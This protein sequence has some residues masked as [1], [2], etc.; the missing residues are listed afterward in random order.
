MK[1]TRPVK[2]QATARLLRLLLTAGIAVVLAIVLFRMIMSDRQRGAPT[3][4]TK[5]DGT[6]A[7]GNT[8]E[9]RLTGPEDRSE[10]T[11]GKPETYRGEGA[12]PSD[13][14]KLVWEMTIEMSDRTLQLLDGSVVVRDFTGEPPISDL[15][16]S[17]DPHTYRIDLTESET[18]SVRLDGTYDPATASL[19]STNETGQFFIYLTP[20]K[21]G[22]PLKAVPARFLPERE[23]TPLITIQGFIRTD[24][25]IVGTFRSVFGPD[26]EYV[27]EP[28]SDG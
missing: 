26:F 15:S 8:A 18:V 23:N 10:G 14:P 19:F 13:D 28:L 7:L 9:G 11:G 2:D 21:L 16:F 27:L 22:A 12:E 1:K 20:K 17:I 5:D 4:A 24:K 3:P 25:N 6:V